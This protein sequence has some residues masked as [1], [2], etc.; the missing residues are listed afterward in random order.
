M[1]ALEIISLAATFAGVACF[2]AVFTML[3][4]SYA[5]AS[6]TQTESGK[7][8]IELID[9]ALN[10]K[11]EKASRRKKISSVVKTVVF[12]VFLVLV[13]PLF[14]FS[15]VNRF[16]DGKPVFGKSIM[17]VASGS[18]SEK[19]E[20]NGYLVTNDLNN[21]FAQYDIIVLEQVVSVDEL[22]VYDVIA[23]RNDAGINVIHRIREK[24]ASG[25]QTKFITRGDA[26]NADDKYQPSFDDV[27][28]VYRGARLPFVGMFV[29]FLQSY[30]GI[31][32]VISLFYCLFMIDY[33]YRKIE[34]C[35]DKRISELLGAIESDELSAK[36]MRA[37]FKETIYYKGYAYRFDENG[38]ID[39]T[40]IPEGVQPAEDTM[41][42]VYDDG[43]EK[44]SREIIIETRKDDA[45]D[46]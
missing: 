9:R 6:I 19:N 35:E 15:L 23:Y 46:R 1:T 16:A 29:M 18:M 20:A 44:L 10:D 34:K 21:Q 12:V 26:N 39:K 30:A 43:E 40:E 32:T 27:L 38:F 37:E 7:R 2:A 31:I 24:V 45:K 25:E 22:S 5:R 3:Y 8:D 14:V 28:G 13:V 41:V 4:R 17:V 36:A 11:S 33:V 42:K